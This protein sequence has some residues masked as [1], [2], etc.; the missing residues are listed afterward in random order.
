[1]GANCVN[2]TSLKIMAVRSVTLLLFGGSWVRNVALVDMISLRIN[3]E[4]VGSDG[5]GS[6]SDVSLRTWS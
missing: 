5:C 4:I 3:G 2:P 6:V 1:V